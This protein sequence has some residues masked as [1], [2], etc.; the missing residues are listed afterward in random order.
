MREH[1]YVGD[2]EAAPQAQDK[3]RVA[4]H[5]HDASACS[6]QRRGDRTGAGSQVEHEIA[7]THARRF[8]Q[9][10]SQLWIS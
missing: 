7:A 6:D 9:L 1:L 4:L 2:G 10:K 8:D 3:P 5:R